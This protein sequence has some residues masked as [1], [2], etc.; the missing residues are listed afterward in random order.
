MPPGRPVYLHADPRNRDRSVMTSD[1]TYDILRNL[2][3]PLVCLTSAWEGKLNGMISNSAIRGSLVPTRPR[4]AVFVLKRT[5]SHDMIFESGAF[6]LHLLHSEQWELI[7]R[8]GFFSG[9]DR[10]KLEDLAYRIGATGSPLLEEAYARLDCRVVNAMDAGAATCFLG[11]AIE[12]ER[13]VADSLMTADHWRTH[14]PE[15]WRAPYEANLAAAQEWAANFGDR[16]EPMVWP[17]LDG[18]D[19]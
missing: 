12:V 16:I 9:R 2:T 10:E 3:T 7:H 1:D 17:G 8:L 4:V 11:E 18:P 5:L 6:G 13:G 19:G 14:M 15:G